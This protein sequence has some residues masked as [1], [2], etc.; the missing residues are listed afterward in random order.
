[1]C[2]WWEIRRVSECSS[3]EANLNDRAWRRL[4]PVGQLEQVTPPE[5][6]REPDCGN[7]RRLTLGVRNRNPTSRM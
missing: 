5:P 1:M 2:G 4:S 3:L 6:K 7:S